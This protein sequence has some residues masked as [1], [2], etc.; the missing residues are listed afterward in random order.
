[1]HPR[2]VPSIAA[3]AALSCAVNACAGEASPALR[4]EI[5]ALTQ[6]LMDALVPGKSDVWQRSLADDALITDEFG[7]RQDKA[8]SVASVKPFPAGISGKIEIRDAHVR[9]YGDTAVVDCEEYETEDYFGHRFVVRYRA[10]ATWVRRGG[11]WKLVAMQDVTLPTPPPAL[12]VRDLALDDYAGAYHYAP[13]RDF[14]VER[15]GDRLML[16]TRS[17]APP[18]ALDPLAKD[19]FMGSDDEKNLFIFRRDAAGKVVE[20]IERRKFNDLHAQRGD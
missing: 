5:V 6:Q 7:R 20:L 15:S 19:V 14:V 12:A 8:E 1:M 4:N 13:Q 9:A 18:H 17:G 3:A 2:I 16:R 11:A 10:T